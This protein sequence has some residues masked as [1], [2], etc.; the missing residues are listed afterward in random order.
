M[1]EIPIL[2]KIKPN[3]KNNEYKNSTISNSVDINNIGVCDYEHESLLT[4]SIKQKEGLLNK[5]L[6][7]ISPT[8]KEMT[9]ERRTENLFNPTGEA[10]EN[11]CGSNFIYIY[12]VKDNKKIYSI[13]RKSVP[14]CKHCNVS[15]SFIEEHEP[16]ID[17]KTNLFFTSEHIKVSNNHYKMKNIGKIKGRSILFDIK[18]D[19]NGIYRFRIINSPTTKTFQTFW[20]STAGSFP[21]GNSEDCVIY[22]SPLEK[23]LSKSPVI[24]SLFK[25]KVFVDSNDDEEPPHLTDQKRIWLLRRIT[26]GG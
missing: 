9:Q 14:G 3:K 4:L 24:L 6:Y 15:L 5:M 7:E 13:F 23:E 21:C 18:S 10:D 2:I 16:K 26:M 17:I 20:A 12:Q 1:K 8:V 25:K 11:N 22:H 19:Y